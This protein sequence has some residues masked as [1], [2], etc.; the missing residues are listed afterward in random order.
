MRSDIAH[1]PPSRPP[2]VDRETWA[3]IAA[4]NAVVFKY[5]RGGDNGEAIVWVES[6]KRFVRLLDCC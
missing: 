1:D 6:R 2:L 4:S 5:S 3:E